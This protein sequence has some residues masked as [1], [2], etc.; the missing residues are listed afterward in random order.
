MV[1]CVSARARR[2]R[3]S[4]HRRLAPGRPRGAP[5]PTTATGSALEHAREHST[6]SSATARTARETNRTNNTLHW[7]ACRVAE[8]FSATHELEAARR[9]LNGR[10][11]RC[12]ARRARDR[13]D[14]PKRASQRGADA[15]TREPQP[16]RPPARLRPAGLGPDAGAGRAEPE[17]HRTPSVRVPDLRRVQRARIPAR[18]TAAWRAGQGVPRDRK[19]AD[20]LRRR[21]VRPRSTWTIDGI[22]HL[23][24]GADWLGIPVPRPV[25][26][27]HHRE[28]RAAHV[29][30]SEKLSRQDR[31]LGGPGPDA[32]PVRVREPVGRVLIRRRATL[33]RRCASYCDAASDRRS[34]AANPTLGLGVSPIRPA[35]RDPAV[36]RLAHRVRTKGAR[37]RSGSLHHENKAGQISGDWGRHPDT[38]V[39]TYSATATS[40][41]T[42]LDWAKTRWATLEPDEKTVMLE[43]VAETPGLHRHRSS[44]PC[45]GQLTPSSTSASASSSTSIRARQPSP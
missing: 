34:S 28:R 14:D 2:V 20:G 4:G 19:P 16:Q 41:R 45:G 33:E 3:C 25:R 12:W 40:Q 5:A 15:S 42:K 22:V 1:E 13:R 9:A 30:S 39:S 38:K 31:R 27:L 44:T 21:R 6:G 37:V 11:A 17:R 23:A 36:R 35:R 24:A 26:V 8:D 18:G 10:S 32:K 7:A 29:C 43:W